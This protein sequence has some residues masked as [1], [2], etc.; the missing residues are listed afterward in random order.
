MLRTFLL[1]GF[2]A[3]LSSGWAQEIKLGKTTLDFGSQMVGQTH[4]MELPFELT[5]GDKVTVNAKVFGTGFSLKENAIEVE[6]SGNASFVV[7]FNPLHNVAYDAELFLAIGEDWEYRVDLKGNGDL[8]IAYYKSTFNLWDKALLDELKRITTSGQ[9]SLGYN[10]A[11]DR[12]YGSIDNKGGSVTC[13]YTAR[14]AKFNTRGGANSNSFNCEHTWPQSKFCGSETDVMKA[15]IHH[16]FATDVNSNSQRGNKPFGVVSGNGSWSEGGSKSSSSIFEPRDGQKGATARAMLY[17]V[18]RYGNCSGFFTGQEKI[19]RQW[20]SENAPSAVERQRN[21]DIF[22]AQKNRNPFVDA[23][24]L[25]ARIHSFTQRSNRPTNA[26]V[27]LVDEL[28]KGNV[29]ATSD[30]AIYYVYLVNTGNADFEVSG[31]TSG[32]QYTTPSMVAV[33]G[34]PGIF[35]FAAPL[36]VASGEKA[37]F[38]FSDPNIDDVEVSFETLVSV[39]SVEVSSSVIG[40][41]D[42]GNRL[43]IHPSLDASSTY[44]TIYDMAGGLV[45]KSAVYGT[46]DL[47]NAVPEG[48]YVIRLTRQNDQTLIRAILR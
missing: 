42:Q 43:H 35:R 34:E 12:M 21:L 6:E 17:M 36:P 30:S 44:M 9:R 46:K 14:T 41:I 29:N 37:V 31:V 33:P 20:A 16:L 47:S 32:F 13:A 27:A 24:D 40:W 39:P 10:T 5:G 8:G 26:E 3:L 28:I 38:T 25:V 45:L 11:R 18:T 2:C 23:P 7:F 4:E 22:S 15:D 1:F 19:L 48:V